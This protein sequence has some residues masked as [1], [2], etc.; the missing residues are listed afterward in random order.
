[1]IYT[2]EVPVLLEENEFDCSDGGGWRY[3]G[4]L[5]CESGS[6]IFCIV[7]MILRTHDLMGLDQ[8]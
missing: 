2:G 1:M 7:S 6:V 8:A 4:C 5:G 3:D